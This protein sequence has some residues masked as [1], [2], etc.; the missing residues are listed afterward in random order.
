[1][2]DQGYSPK[3]PA[4]TNSRPPQG[5]SALCPS[6]PKGLTEA[7]TPSNGDRA[8]ALL[9]D[10]VWQDL[11]KML[12]PEAHYYGKFTFDIQDS[13][14]VHTEKLTKVRTPIINKG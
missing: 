7:K 8:R 5:G 1:M 9:P 10:E 4:P 3:G 12:N 14:I 6:P 13:R 2:S 11:W